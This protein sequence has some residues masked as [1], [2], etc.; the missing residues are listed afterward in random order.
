MEAGT[1]LRRAELRGSWYPAAQTELER[2]L[3]EWISE[4][5]E[6]KALA[7]VAPHAG[8]IYSGKLA[9]AAVAALRPAETVAIFGGHLGGQDPVLMAFEDGFQTTGGSLEADVELREALV[10]ELKDAGLPAPFEDA[11]VDNSVEV[12]LPLVKA[13]QPKA[14]VLWLRCPPRLDSK[15]VGAALGRASAFLGR[16]V[17]CV[18]S[19]DLTHYGPAYGFSPAG[20]G[21]G[22]RDWVTKVNDKSFIDAL[23]DMNCEAALLAARRKGAACSSGAAVA[24]LG[25]A[26]ESGATEAHLLRYSTSL[27]VRQAE[28]FVGY[29][30]LAFV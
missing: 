26:L 29:A 19:T 13:L 11:G 7:A 16:R 27:E 30:A 4:S 18:G 3:S 6:G 28:S 5:S 23:L 2:L 1:R 15:E 22:A 21:D 8:W 12:L 25:F 14:K 10:S 9:A 20:R 17:A 24:A